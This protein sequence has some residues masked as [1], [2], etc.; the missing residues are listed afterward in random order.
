MP[1]N[2]GRKPTGR[3]APT[4]TSA[5]LSPDLYSTLQDIAKHKKVS[6]AWVIRD[7]VEK[8]ITDQW[9]LIEKSKP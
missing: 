9:P 1:I 8:Y 2:R 4:R 7:A 6:V 3:V 5:S